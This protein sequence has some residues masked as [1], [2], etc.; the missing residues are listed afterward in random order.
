MKVMSMLIACVT[1]WGCQAQQPDMSFDRPGLI[2]LLAQAEQQGV[3]D[4]DRHILVVRH[5]RK[6]SPDCNALNCQLSP[7]GEAMVA[8][9]H[10]IIGDTPVDMALASAACRTMLT[11]AAGAR[12]VIAHQAAD[13]YSKG[14]AEDV[15]ISRSRQNALVQTREAD[16]RWTIIGEHSNTVCTWILFF[17]D[18]AS[19]N[20]AGCTN[21]RLPG[22]AYGD[23]FW[24][25]RAEGQWKLVVL[26]KVF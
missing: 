17:T 21:G 3:R 4:A 26:N 10:Q 5:A 9:L 11:A 24:L 1:I 8:R 7:E 22:E 18:E 13:G 19:A 6:I 14:C 15:N 20:R 25:Y 2:E 23:V 16:A 12:D